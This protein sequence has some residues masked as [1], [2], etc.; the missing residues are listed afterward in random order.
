MQGNKIISLAEEINLEPSVAL[1]K[2]LHLWFL[3]FPKRMR[4][5]VNYLESIHYLVLGERARFFGNFEENATFYL[6]YN[7][8]RPLTEVAIV[9]SKLDQGWQIKVEDHYNWLHIT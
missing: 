1:L 8:L 7:M 6:F 5:R 2:E 3:S 9:A 4:G